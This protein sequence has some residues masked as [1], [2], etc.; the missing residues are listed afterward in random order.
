[1]LFER[2]F[3]KTFILFERFLKHE[4]LCYLIEFLIQHLYYLNDF[5]N[6]KNILFDRIFN[7]IFILFERF[8]KHEQL[9]YLN[10]FFKI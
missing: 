3:H 9:F 5:Q 4:Q 10:E 2:I 6:M 1:M 7:I 8:S